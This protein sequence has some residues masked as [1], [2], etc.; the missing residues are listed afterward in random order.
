MVSIIIVVYNGEKFIEQA[1]ESVFNQTYKDIELIIVDDGSTDGTRDIIKSYQNIK[2]IYEENR[3]QAVARNLGI[4]HSKGEYIAFLDADDLYVSDKIEKQVEV[5]EKNKD[6]DVVYNDLKVV[7][8][9]LNYLSTLK[10][11][12]I[13]V[14]R[15]DLLANVIY[16]QVVQG[17]VC[18]MLRRKCT[19]KVKWNEELDYVNDY[20]YIINLLKYYNFKY[21]EEELYIYRRHGN[22]FSN[23]HDKTMEE[24]KKLIRSLGIE[25]IQE[26]VNE[27]TFS[28]DDKRF[29]L[30]KIYMKIDNYEEAMKILEE[31]IFRSSNELLYFY[32]GL[33]NYKLNNMDLA[34]EN[35]KKAIRINSELPEAYNNLGCCMFEKKPNEAKECFEKALEIRNE[36]MDAKNNL[37]SIVNG[38]GN[39]KVTERELRKTLTLY[40]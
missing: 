23:N 24:E 2:Y 35:Y 38:Y 11:E 19:K 26:I 7:D 4:E 29:L 1:I 36:Y 5:L 15:Q 16:R 39:I 20:D 9:K 22:N 25:D 12:G 3:G 34:V 18:I 27:S 8:E 10:S 30:A 14:R 21:L 31:D 32:L 37:Q 6:I 40:S 28:D 33:C 17:P 13:Y